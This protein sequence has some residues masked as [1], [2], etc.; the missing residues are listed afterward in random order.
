M[1]RWRYVLIALLVVLLAADLGYRAWSHRPYI[2]TAWR[3]ETGFVTVQYT[4]P[5][6]GTADWRFSTSGDSLKYVTDCMPRVE[7]GKA[8][9]D[10]VRR[11]PPK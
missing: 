5:S 4:V 9:P 2:V 3:V 7:V 1:T 6:G 11:A 10:C 8:I